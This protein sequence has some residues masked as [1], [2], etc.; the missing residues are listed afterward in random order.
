MRVNSQVRLNHN[1][2]P[3]LSLSQASQLIREVAE[4]AT[5]NRSYS[6]DKSD[7]YACRSET[8]QNNRTPSALYTDKG[9]A[10]S[11]QSV[12]RGRHLSTYA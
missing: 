1:Q 2:I 12:H 9:H 6:D 8:R 7:G 5:F 3:V 10:I 11:S 4:T